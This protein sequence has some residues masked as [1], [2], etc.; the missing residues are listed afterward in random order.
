MAIC[1]LDILKVDDDVLVEHA[2]HGRW[3]EPDFM[4]L[5]KIPRTLACVI[6][7]YL[8]IY[9]EFYELFSSLNMKIIDV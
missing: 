2:G 3:P 1:F 4:S 7:K 6:T 9:F 8:S 5:S